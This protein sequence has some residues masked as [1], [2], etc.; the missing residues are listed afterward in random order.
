MTLDLFKNVLCGLV[1]I[2][3]N[4]ELNFTGG[5]LFGDPCLIKIEQ[6]T[7]HQKRANADAPADQPPESALDKRTQLLIATSDGTT[8]SISV[9]QTADGALGQPQLN[10]SEAMP[11]RLLPCHVFDK[12]ATSLPYTVILGERVSL[13]VLKVPLPNDPSHAELVQF[14]KN[15]RI[16]IR[17]TRDQVDIS[18]GAKSARFALGDWHEAGNYSLR[19][20]RLKLDAPH[21]L[22]TPKPVLLIASSAVYAQLTKLTINH[23]KFLE[24]YH[25]IILPKS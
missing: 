1:N 10:I 24:E 20:E 17:F 2:N 23:A 11:Y 6:L 4:S 19:V 18:I 16:L 22:L 13:T 7:L 3:A 21:F 5:K 12:T 25:L 15:Q 8:Q 9:E 14:A